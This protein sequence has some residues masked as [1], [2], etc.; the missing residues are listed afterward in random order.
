M[1][2]PPEQD[3]TPP[4]AWRRAAATVTDAL[5]VFF[6]VWAL[7]VVQ[8]LWFMGRLSHSVD[9][10]PWGDAFAAT[11][12][13]VVAYVL[14]SLVFLFWNAG[15]T[16]GKE[17]F[18]VRVATPDGSVPSRAACVRRTVAVAVL[19]LVPPLWLGLLLVAATG[20][21]VLAGRG[22]GRS[23][24][25]LVAGTRT[26]AYVPVQDEARRRRRDARN[27]QDEAAPPTAFML[28][29]G[30]KNARRFARTEREAEDRADRNPN[31]SQIDR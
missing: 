25:D 17:V 16:P 18:G 22:R 21:P 15:R 9:P 29:I 30:R 12:V 4:A 24:P 5:T 2:Q 10:E 3:L 31:P 7:A 20:L 26:V 11:V 14:Y 23:W 27:A 19:F 6:L 28:L 1:G 13:Y 8:V